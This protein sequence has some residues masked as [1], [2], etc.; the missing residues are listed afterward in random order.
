MIREGASKANRDLNSIDIAAYTCFSISEDYEAAKEKA[1]QV[2]AFIVAGSPPQVLERHG[3]PP[4]AAD[5]I[6]ENIAKGPKGFIE[7]FNA[8]TDEMVEAFAIYGRPDDIVE[9]VNTLVKVG[10]TQVVVGSP[11]GPKKKKSIQL[12]KEQVLP[13]FK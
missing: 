10:V 9:K 8:V 4:E 12:I 5:I 3:I 6:R 1:K 11:I 7:A 13:H 2:V